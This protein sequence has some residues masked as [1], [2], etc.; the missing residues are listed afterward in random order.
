MEGGGAG[1][2]LAHWMTHGAPPMDALAIDSRRFGSWADRDYRV[3]KAIECFGLQFGVHYPHEERRAGRNLRL[4]PL[5]NLMVER[6]AVMG[7]AHGWERPNWFADASGAD[8]DDT[9]RRADWFAP[10]SR[11]VAAAS[12]RIALA[13][14]SVF[15]KFDV[16]GPDVA[17]FLEELGANR[18]PK[19]GRISLTHALTPA[20]G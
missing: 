5:H 18:V 16:T 11:E 19:V 9:F 17:A 10:V 6:G 2:F 12:T 13:D 1:W 14:L 4:S 15:A 20:G 7:T 3:T 8:S